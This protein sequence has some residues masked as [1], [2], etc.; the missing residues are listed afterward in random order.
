M[1]VERCS[2]MPFMVR[3]V[4]SSFLLRKPRNCVKRF[5]CYYRFTEIGLEIFVDP[6]FGSKRDR[7][8]TRSILVRP[9]PGCWFG[10]S[11]LELDDSAGRSTILL[12]VIR[13][14]LKVKFVVA[15]ARPF[16]FRSFR[17]RLCFH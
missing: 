13:M 4:R 10:L 1:S 6:D 14:A 5:L 12:A 17:E 8:L 3:G 11:R 15:G 2:A 7:R 16:L 9:E